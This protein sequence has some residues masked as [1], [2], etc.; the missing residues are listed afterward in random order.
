[1]TTTNLR[2]SPPRPPLLLLYYVCHLLYL[3]MNFVV[4]FLSKP[5]FRYYSFGFTASTSSLAEIDNEEVEIK[6]MVAAAEVMVMVA[7]TD[8]LAEV[9]N[10]ETEMMVM[11]VV[12]T[13]FV[14]G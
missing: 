14:Y 9:E 11:V 1:M 5:S 6:M 10:E 13:D 4:F 2:R 12:V 3:A 7:E 8:S